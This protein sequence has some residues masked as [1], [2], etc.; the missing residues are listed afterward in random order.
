MRGCNSPRHGGSTARQV[1]VASEA[2]GL[3]HQLDNFFPKV[4]IDGGAIRLA[5]GEQKPSADFAL[6]EKGRQIMLSFWEEICKACNVCTGR[7]DPR[8]RDHFTDSLGIFQCRVFKVYVET[9]NDMN[10]L[11]PAGQPRIK[12]GRTIPWQ[13]VVKAVPDWAREAVDVAAALCL[14]LI[15]GRR[16]ILEFSS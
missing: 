16:P 9:V 11:L 13:F 7:E 5:D 8:M 10:V 4:L 14:A 3:G 2:E 1:C 6:D 12:Y 15:G